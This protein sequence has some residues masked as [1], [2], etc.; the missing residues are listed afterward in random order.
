MDFSLQATHKNFLQAYATPTYT[1]DLALCESF[2]MLT[3]TDPRKFS[4]S[5]VSHYYTVHALPASDLRVSNLC[6]VSHKEEG[7]LLCKV[8]DLWE[9]YLKLLDAELGAV[10]AEE[11]DDAV[12]LTLLLHRVLNAGILTVGLQGNVCT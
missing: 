6:D 4:S 7:D 9:S 12:Q 3:S 5:K 1:I 10:L 11:R 8:E 2:K